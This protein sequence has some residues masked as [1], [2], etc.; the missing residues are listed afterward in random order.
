L[1]RQID[2][3]GVTVHERAGAARF[4]DPHTF[5]AEG[6]RAKA[7]VADQPDAGAAR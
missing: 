2:G 6:G 3:V 4:A 5:V 1:R 7:V